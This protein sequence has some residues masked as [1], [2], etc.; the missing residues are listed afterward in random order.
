MKLNI[1]RTS[2][3]S[4]N[5]SIGSYTY[6]EEGDTS[7]KKKIDKEKTFFLLKE[8]CKLKFNNI[9]VELKFNGD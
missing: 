1:T 5:F 6:I 7:L 9:L 3:H 4:S 8:C 2:I